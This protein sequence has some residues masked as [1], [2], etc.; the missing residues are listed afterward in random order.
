MVLF[1]LVVRP[2]GTARNI[3]ARE[4]ADERGPIHDVDDPARQEE[5]R[6]YDT[7]LT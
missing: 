4:L 6:P 5:R 3:P 7:V 2:H 1:A